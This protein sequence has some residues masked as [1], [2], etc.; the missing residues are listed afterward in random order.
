M[1]TPTDWRASGFTGWDWIRESE[2]GSGYCFVALRVT[3]VPLD[4]F[5]WQP[6]HI[7]AVRAS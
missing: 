1:V 3:V 4:H 6:P 5:E 2:S 7:R